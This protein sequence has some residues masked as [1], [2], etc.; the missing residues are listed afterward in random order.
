MRLAFCLFAALWSS[1]VAALS[2]S[3]SRLLVVL[4]DAADVKEYSQ[5]FGD[6]VGE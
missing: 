5:F 4:D 6:L 2:V 1:C 3:G